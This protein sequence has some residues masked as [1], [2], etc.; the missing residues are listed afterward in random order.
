MQEEREAFEL[1]TQQAVLIGLEQCGV[2]QPSGIADVNIFTLHSNVN[3]IYNFIRATISLNTYTERHADIHIYTQ[4]THAQID[5]GT[6][7]HADTCVQIYI[8]TYTDTYRQTDA[9]FVI[10]GVL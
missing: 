6:H 4:H 2:E 8:Q 3:N 10:F 9:V 7:R 5:T 1:C